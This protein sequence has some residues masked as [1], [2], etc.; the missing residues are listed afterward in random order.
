MAKRSHVDLSMG[1]VPQE[2][3]ASDQLMQEQ[4]AS[5]MA[6]EDAAKLNP[7]PEVVKT[8]V[9]FILFKLVNTSR[10]GRLNVDGIDDVINPKTG[11]MER[12]RLLAG[13]DTIWQK[14]QKDVT[15]EYVKQNRRSLQ[16]EGK[17]CR[18]PEWD[19]TALEFAK[20]CR[21]FIESP[22]Y[23]ARGSKHAFFEW[24]PAR[25][26]E[27]R[28]AKQK[29]RLDAMQKALA[30]PVEQMRKHAFYLGVHAVDEVGIQKTDEGIRNDYFGKAEV[31]PVRFLESFEQPIVNISYLVK[32]AI[33]EGK[34]DLGRTPGSAYWA[35]NGGHIGQYPQTQT[36]ADYLIGLAMGHTK[37]GKLFLETLQSISS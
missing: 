37:E 5:Q 14:E 34:I 18:I 19:H 22:G 36:P 35:S 23:K 24:N 29:K 33:T 1:A 12:I 13:V 20:T 16:F 17:F 4:L 26:A 32:K 28:A 11:K 6:L 3:H 2:T 9:K 21:S 8:D 30:A 27:A 31:D 15:D 7:T 25:M 10:K